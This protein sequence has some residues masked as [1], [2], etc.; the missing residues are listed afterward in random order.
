M[1]PRLPRI[2]PKELLRALKKDGYYEHHQRGSHQ[3]LKH[4]IKKGLIT[5]PMHRTE[6][7]LKTLKTII[8]Q[9]NIS[10]DNL[11]LLLR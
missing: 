10:V 8:D 3:Y 11:V 5:V 4:P 7:K 9:A 1:S 2:T 6:L